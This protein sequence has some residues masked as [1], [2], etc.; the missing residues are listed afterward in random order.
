MDM[1]VSKYINLLK[2]CSRSVFEELGAGWKEEIYQK[3]M[4]VALREKGIS[5]ET[6][7]ALPISYANHVIGEA[8]PDLIIWV[9]EQ[10][11]RIAIVV[12]LKA[13]SGIKQDHRTQ[14]ERYIK[15]LRKQIHENEFV[16]PTG[17]VINFVKDSTNGKIYDGVEELEGVQVL[18]VAL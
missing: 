11:K 5:Y 3:A 13:D 4:E 14:V 10:Q 17:F 7:R 2:Q 6:Q 9:K 8:I 1:Q 18:E 16:Y 12:D 15:E